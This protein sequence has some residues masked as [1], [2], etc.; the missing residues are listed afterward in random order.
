MEPFEYNIIQDNKGYFTDL[1]TKR[2]KGSTVEFNTEFRC[3]ML[4][5]IGKGG[6]GWVWMT[7][8]S[9][10]DN[11]IMVAKIE[12]TD[13]SY[14]LAKEATF[15]STLKNDNF[16]PEYL[17]YKTSSLYNVLFLEF[18]GP[19]LLDVFNHHT[20]LYCYKEVLLVAI[21]TLEIMKY[22]HSRYIVHCDIKP[23]NFLVRPYV[24]DRSSIVL[25]DFGMAHEWCDETTGKHIP[26]WAYTG[27]GTLDYMSVDA[28]KNM[29]V[30]RKDDLESLSYM[31]CFLMTGTLPWFKFDLKEYNLVLEMKDD[32]YAYELF[33]SCPDVFIDF[34]N[35]IRSLV[36]GQKPKYKKY[37]KMFKKAYKDLGYGDYL[38]DWNIDHDFEE[39]V[40]ERLKNVE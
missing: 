15:Y 21:R 17:G 8:T 20:S 26:S 14:L 24:R 29:A 40:T 16:F 30:C 4:K 19:T 35:I 11:R 33:D 39:I 2:I 22:L 28:M 1:D 23:I 32:I 37:I 13:L 31:F 7:E 9:E 25:S 3:K 27:K 38:W 12:L 5:M 36:F 18:V 10:P 34:H 6:Y